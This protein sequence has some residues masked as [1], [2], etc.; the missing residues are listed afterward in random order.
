MTTLF[1]SDPAEYSNNLN[2]TIDDTVL[3]RTKNPK[4]IGLTLDPKLTYNEHIK[5]AKTKADKNIKILKALTSTHW[6]KSKK[7][8]D[9][10]LQKTY[11]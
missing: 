5:K 8:L 9:Q 1:T 3:P 7:N 11:T 4:I 2:L 10:Y 6:G